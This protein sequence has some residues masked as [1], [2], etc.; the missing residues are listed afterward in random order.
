MAGIGMYEFVRHRQSQH[1]VFR[2]AIPWEFN[3]MEESIGISI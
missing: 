1:F 3:G 2:F